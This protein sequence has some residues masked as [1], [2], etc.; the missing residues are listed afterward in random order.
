MD[1][2]PPEGRV[3]ALYAA[4]AAG[5]DVASFVVRAIWLLCLLYLIAIVGALAAGAI[6]AVF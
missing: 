4:A 3:R 2:P 1:T 6:H 5:L